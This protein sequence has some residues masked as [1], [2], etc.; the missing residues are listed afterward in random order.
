VQGSDRLPGGLRK[1]GR[2]SQSPLKDLG[3]P[4][5]GSHAWSR[6][7]CGVPDVPAEV[8]PSGRQKRFVVYGGRW[9]KTDLT[10]KYRGRVP[11]G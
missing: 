1:R 9:E 4:S 11:G 3:P 6:P 2:P 8:L 7:R 5:N 10:Y